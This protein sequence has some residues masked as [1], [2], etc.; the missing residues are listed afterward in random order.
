M[1][2]SIIL[3]ILFDY[4]LGSIPCSQLIATWRIGQDLREVGEGNVGSR[5]VWHVVGPSW[6]VLATALDA[7]KG[8]IAVEVGV[9]AS[10]PLA[11]ILLGGAAALLGHQ[12]PL[13]LRG[14][15][16]K[17]LSTGLGVLLSLSPASTL[18]ALAVLAL[19]YFAFHDFNVAVVPGA[20]AVILLL[21][22]FRQPLWVPAYAIGLALLLAAKKLLDRPHEQR[23]W[24]SHPWR[25]AAR[26]GWTS[27]A[28]EEAPAPDTRPR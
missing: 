27:G 21:I 28:D 24:A 3:L 11:G 15:G 22:P 23:V 1:Q 20:I 5:N 17:G 13:F 12:F 2:L 7:L 10:L 4:L 16:G 14:R 6:G 26:P 25:S 9:A 19:A 18:C 8:V